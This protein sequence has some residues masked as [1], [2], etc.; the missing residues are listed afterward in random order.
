MVSSLRNDTGAVSVSLKTERQD[1]TFT[2]T[3]MRVTGAVSTFDDETK[4]QS[5]SLY[6]FACVASARA[7]VPTRCNCE[8]AQLSNS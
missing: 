8:Q 4:D 6:R 2:L 5:A 1:D 3:G 7:S